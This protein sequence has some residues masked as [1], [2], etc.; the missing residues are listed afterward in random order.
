M[1][2]NIFF[3]PQAGQIIFKKHL[4]EEECPYQH[5]LYTTLVEGVI[6]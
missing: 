4:D 5:F 1:Q 6:S 3:L 2:L